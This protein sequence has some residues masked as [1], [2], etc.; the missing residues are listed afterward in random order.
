MTSV[1]LPIWF[2]SC[3]LPDSS[4]VS[5]TVSLQDCQKL[6]VAIV[7]FIVLWGSHRSISSNGRW[8]YTLIVTQ[9]WSHTQKD[10]H[11]ETNC[12]MHQ[13]LSHTSHA[14]HPHRNKTQAHR[15]NETLTNT[16][17]MVYNVHWCVIAISVLRKTIK[18]H[19]GFNISVFQQELQA[20]SER[21]L[22]FGN[23]AKMLGVYTR[24]GRSRAV[25]FTSLV[26][27]ATSFTATWTSTKRLFIMSACWSPVMW[28]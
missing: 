14:E 7:V 24:S 13:A 22:P 1:R 20:N 18:C 8:F 4:G 23:Y 15:Q 3:R 2:V 27:E 11:V 10:T 5:K 6:P 17:R 21:A 25:L 9:Y 26:T 12:H 16:R 19:C 28:T